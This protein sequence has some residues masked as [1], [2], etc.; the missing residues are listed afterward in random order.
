VVLVGDRRAEQGHDAVAGELVDRAL[1]PVHALAEDLEEAPHD[2]APRLG[3]LLLGEVHRAH[4]VGEQHRHV[5]ALTLQDGSAGADLLGQVLRDMRARVVQPRGLT[6]LGCSTPGGCGHRL[7][8]GVAEPLTGRVGGAAVRASP[9]D[10]QRRGAVPA[11]TGL[12]RIW[13]AAAWAVHASGGRVDRSGRAYLRH[14]G[15]PKSSHPFPPEAPTGSSGTGHHRGAPQAKHPS[16]RRSARARSRNARS[17]AYGSNQIAGAAYHANA[18]V[19]A[20]RPPASSR[21]L[22]ATR[23]DCPG[24]DARGQPRCWRASEFLMTM[25]KAGRA[26]HP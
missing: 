9:G 21:Q 4:H 18:R 19:S 22:T 11:E 1:E 20:A 5:L 2:L 7:A 17:P 16:S 23:R 10:E 12:R 26:G 15:L 6:M 13:V 24:R 3:I 25:Q 14:C 8:A